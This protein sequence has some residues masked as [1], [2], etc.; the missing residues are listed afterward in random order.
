MFRSFFLT[1]APVQKLDGGVSFAAHLFNRYL[2]SLA[3][4]C[5]AI[6]EWT[7]RS[8]VGGDRFSRVFWVKKMAS[9]EV[10]RLTF[11]SASGIF[12]PSF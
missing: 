5:F 9:A 8:E 6:E 12:L 4:Y 1:H 11:A 3:S 7:G 10:F 2:E